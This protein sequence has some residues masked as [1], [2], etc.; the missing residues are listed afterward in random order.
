MSFC[1]KTF[2]T[3]MINGV[4]NSTI[5]DTVYFDG[6]PDFNRTDSG[7]MLSTAPT[8][9]R[10][11]AN[12]TVE[13]F[14]WEA[15]GMNVATYFSG[16]LGASL[17]SDG[18][19]SGN[20]Q[21]SDVLSALN[22]TNNISFLMDNVAVSMT[23]YIR[24]TSNLVVHGQAGT[25]ETFT[26]VTWYWITLPAS[27]VL[28]AFLF[29]LLAIF[30]S[31]KYETKVW[32]HSSL[33]LLFHGLDQKITHNSLNELEEMEQEAEVVRVRL[34]KTEKDTLMLFNEL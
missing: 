22:E 15:I 31:R 21:S 33:A 6:V 7:Y 19:I 5:L 13:Y 26:H 11:G 8:A 1:V 10:P 2:A 32:K 9:G 28:G 17:S 25:T 34:R 16:A 27:V 23:N 18:F 20:W 4:L 12:Y 3:A 14:T 29:L 30:E 24:S